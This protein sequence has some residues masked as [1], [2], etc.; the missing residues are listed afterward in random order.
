MGVFGRGRRG[1]RWHGG[2]DGVPQEVPLTAA[3]QLIASQTV[4]PR[5]LR[6]RAPH[7]TLVAR[8]NRQSVVKH[9]DAYADVA[10]D[11]PEHHIDPCDPR[12]ERPDT[13]GLGATAW[14]RGLPG[15]KRAQMGLHIALA[16]LRIGIDFES[17]L[18]RGLLE[19]ASVQEPGSAELR[20]AYHEVIEEAQHSLMFQEFIHR[21]GLPVRGLQGA[22]L[23]G[24]R[25]VPRLGR[26]FPALFFIHVLG[27]EAPIDHAQKL[28]LARQGALHPLLRRIMQ[29]HVTEEARH[30]CFAKSW[31][32]T[33]VP[34][35][36]ALSMLRLRLH[37]P[38]ILSVMA[39]QM[40]EPPRWLLDA[41]AVP[42]EVRRE[43]FVLDMEHRRLLAEGVRPLR[44]LC[45][46]VGILT[47]G[48]AP[49]WRALGLLPAQTSTRSL[50]A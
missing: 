20:Y 39:R 32:R 43:A 50:P 19:F 33:N 12:F 37:V 44:D 38:F 48:L 30:I 9:F 6:A 18:S 36:G 25:R 27:G 47:P 29:I 13:H 11:T 34:Q 35:L 1:S 28:E 2:C 8:L 24:S 10:W 31:V 45:A 42:K 41:Y 49:L 17:V 5:A 23:W 40:M 4:S 15:E 21:A 22:D 26:T 46:E 16:Q 14:Y 3:A 7:P